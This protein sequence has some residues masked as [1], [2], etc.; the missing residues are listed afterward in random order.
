MLLTPSRTLFSYYPWTQARGVSAMSSGLQV[1][2]RPRAH[3]PKI[4]DYTLGPWNPL[5]KGL[6][7]ARAY[8]SLYLSAWGP[9]PH[10]VHT[11][12][13]GTILQGW[14]E[15]RSAAAGR[16]QGWGVWAGGRRR[17]WRPTSP[18]VY[19]RTARTLRIANSGLAFSVIM[20]L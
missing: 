20:K 14:A 15:L 16:I 2:S 8:I 17:G 4:L 10:C 19:L 13:Q 1:T 12:P 6:S 11:K 5:T 9:D 7:T 18:A 3:C